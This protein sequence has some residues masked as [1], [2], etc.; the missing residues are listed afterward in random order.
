MGLEQASRKAAFDRRMGALAAEI[1]DR[2]L[3]AGLQSWLNDR[4]GRGTDA[5]EEIAELIRH[6]AGE[7]WL[8]QHEAGGI[9]F[10]RAIKPGGQA[11]RFSVDVVEM[12]N[13]KGP[14]HV[15]PQ[16]EVGMVVPIKGDPRFDDF[17]AGWYVYPARSDHYPTVSGGAAY[18]LYLL[19]D[20]AIEFTGR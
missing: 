12:A 4:Y 19:P 8:C 9:R 2:P 14:H 13:V 20:G 6:G 10:G 5:F 11:G 18:V 3:D 1:G 7:G 16:G 17:D 15:H